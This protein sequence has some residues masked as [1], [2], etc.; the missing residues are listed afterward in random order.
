MPNHSQQT[1]PTTPRI[2]VIIPAFNEEDSIG[3]VLN[4]IPSIVEEV[5]VV[6]NASTDQTALRA[7]E[8]G[9]IVLHESRRGYGSACLQGLSYALPKAF[10]IIVFLDADYSDHPDELPSV[11]RPIIED[12]CDMVIGSRAIG[13][14][15]PG[16]MTPQALFG[17]W[18]ST[19]LI[20][21][22]WGYRFTDLGPFRAITTD[23]LKE[24]KMEDTNY[25]W[26]V[27]MQIKAA[28]HK[29]KTTE[30][31]VS[32]RRRIGVSK[33]SGTLSGTIKAGWKIL[34]TIAKY[35]LRKS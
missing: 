20:R 22:I 8:A 5:V 9:A 32:Y 2:A 21:L 14:R 3:L 10:D 6:N 16:A 29:L 35:G 19:S 26:T 13:E 27:E 24:I 17:N 33:I 7:V 25:G 34:Y 12:G 4:D 15:E 23:A 30:V 11:I 31:P 1:T 28:R 18:L